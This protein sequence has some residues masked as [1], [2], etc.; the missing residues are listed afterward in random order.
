MAIDEMEIDNMPLRTAD[1]ERKRK[2]KNKDASASTSPSKKRKQ[3]PSSKAAAPQHVQDSDPESPFT[4]TTATLYLPLS[5]ISIS[6][7]HALASL[8]AEHLSP[9]LLTYFPPLKGIVL[10][11]SHASI[12]SN[13]PANTS[14]FSDPNPEPLTLAKSADEYGVLYVYLTATFLMFRPKRGQTLDGWVNVQ[15]E[16][17]LGAV[18]FNL[19]SVGVERKRLP[20]NWKWVPP[21]EEAET[22]ALTDD[23]SA[24][25]GDMADFDAEKECFKPA[26]LSAE[27]IA[28]EGE[29]DAS[30]HTGYFQS[31]S[32]HRVTGSVRFRVV[33]VDVIPGSER[34]RGFLSIEGTMLS[35]EEEE[36]LSES[37]RQGQSLPPSFFPSPKKLSGSIPVMDVPAA[38]AVQELSTVD[39]HLE[40]SPK[41]EKKEKKEKKV[42]EKKEK[43]EKK[44]TSKS[45]KSKDE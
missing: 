43:K 13:P 37:E 18:V 14:S 10:A 31:V 35:V 9:L 21:G 24:S 26:S 42:K 15:S 23:D 40:P 30:A 1:A 17:F 38:S 33:D 25:D 11:Y 27:E 32:G 4:L 20:S 41:K 28:I 6:P 36:R 22:P 34:D 8:L 7:T 2:S 44:S 12:S 39:V 29:E 3:T 19:F 5:P 16:G 45:K